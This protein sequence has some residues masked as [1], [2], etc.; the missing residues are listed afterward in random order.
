MLWP[1]T[2]RWCFYAALVCGL[3]IAVE[4][5]EKRLEQRGY[6]RAQAEFTQQAILASESARQRERE[7]QQQ[8]KDAENE[9][10]QREKAI[11]A[12]AT[13]ARTERDRLRSEIATSRNRMSA[14]S[15]AAVREYA[16][17]LSSVFEECAGQL[18]EL[19]RSA[20]GHASDSLMYQRGWVKH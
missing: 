18:E 4:L 11:L 14:A 17:T 9:A 15:A 13:A 7:L 2:Y 3:L 1:A 10:K 16:S 20:S 6:D 5:W 19:A 8:V 12:D